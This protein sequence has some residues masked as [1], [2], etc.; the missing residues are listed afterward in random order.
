VNDS[1]EDKLVSKLAGPIISKFK[2]AKDVSDVLKAM[3]AVY[4]AI[5]SVE[6]GTSF[7]SE[8]FD[9]KKHTATV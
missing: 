2:K 4:P 1:S 5:S 9:T 6:A 8:F 3:D 7:M